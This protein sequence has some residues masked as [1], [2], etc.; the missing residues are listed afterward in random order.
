MLDLPQ[1]L[2]INT[3]ESCIFFF[4]FKREQME[5]LMNRVLDFLTKRK[6]E[7]TYEVNVSPADVSC[8]HCLIPK[9]CSNLGRPF[10]LAIVNLMFTN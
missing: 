9:I 8:L 6:E 3:F 1:S 10:T 5:R 4:V 2:L 7:N